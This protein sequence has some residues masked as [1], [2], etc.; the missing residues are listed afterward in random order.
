MTAVTHV[1]L[2]GN[3][4]DYETQRLSWAQRLDARGIAAARRDVAHNPA[5][6]G[7]LIDRNGEF[8]LHV[9]EQPPTRE[10]ALAALL[11]DDLFAGEAPSYRRWLAELPGIRLL[12][13]LPGDSVSLA[14]LVDASI[15]LLKN[16]GRI[17]RDFFDLLVAA[18][19][20][21]YLAITAVRQLW[22]LDFANPPPTHRPPPSNRDDDITA[23]LL[24]DTPT[25][26]LVPAAGPALRC[27]RLTLQPGQATTWDL[28]EPF[29][30][31]LRLHLGPSAHLGVGSPHYFTYG[32]HR[33]TQS[34]GLDDGPASVVVVQTQP[35]VRRTTLRIVRGSIDRHH[36]RYS[37]L[38][39]Y[40][41]SL[42]SGLPGRV[43]AL[44]APSAAVAPLILW[45]MGVV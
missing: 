23:E 28:G 43:I 44:H 14:D 15:N 8:H 39:D 31:P 2:G 41:F 7:T 3:T 13:L 45:L 10:A 11:R 18:R 40:E 12:V 35:S 21:R 33:K 24:R 22:L 27:R 1:T 17:D 16:R 25:I 4:T 29:S 6:N 36:R 20:H 37:L 38:P 19:P 26:E 30:P 42:A 9:V 34:A 5:C 32:S